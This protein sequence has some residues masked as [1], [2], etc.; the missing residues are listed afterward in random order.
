MLTQIDNTGND[1]HTG[2]IIPSTVLKQ[3]HWDHPPQFTQRTLDD[4][5]IRELLSRLRPEGIERDSYYISR[6]AKEPHSNLPFV[7]VTGK[8]FSFNGQF[9]N[10][11][12]NQRDSLD[13][14]SLALWD[15]ANEHT[16]IC[17]EYLDVTIPDKTIAVMSFE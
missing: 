13:V 14:A 5:R 4:S 6:V 12:V 9:T 3:I 11:E 10:E 16:I 8:V 15:T 7:Y 2:H 17:S 1:P